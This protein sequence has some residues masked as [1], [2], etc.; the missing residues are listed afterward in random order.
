MKTGSILLGA[1]AALLFACAS[2]TPVSAEHQQPAPVTAPRTERREL[3]TSD[4]GARTDGA[5]C[6]DAS[7][8]GA[9]HPPPCSRIERMFDG[10]AEPDYLLRIVE[11]CQR[12][13]PA[14]GSNDDALCQMAG[15]SYKNAVRSGH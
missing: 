4:H 8:V 2:S 13:Q 15:F 11:E 7:A 5:P 14:P 3:V 12:A 1:C 9:T 6:I 10:Y